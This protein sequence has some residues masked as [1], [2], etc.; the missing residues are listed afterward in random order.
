M[1]GCREHFFCCCDLQHPGL[2]LKYISSN[3]SSHFKIHLQF[4]VG[5]QDVVH[6]SYVALLSNLMTKK[7]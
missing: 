4:E 5:G 2:N 6:N 3:N 1:P 7:E